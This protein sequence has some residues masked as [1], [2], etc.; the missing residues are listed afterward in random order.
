M[1]LDVPPVRPAADRSALAGARLVE[2]RVDVFSQ[3]LHPV[4]RERPLQSG[5]AVGLEMVPDLVQVVEL[6]RRSIAAHLPNG[7][8][9][10]RAANPREPAAAATRRR[11]RRPAQRDECGPPRWLRKDEALSRNSGAP[12]WLRKDEALS[13]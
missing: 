8:P 6:V 10:A 9:R 1:D 3:A 11:P 13:P 12:R 7:T 5:D 2:R 4:A